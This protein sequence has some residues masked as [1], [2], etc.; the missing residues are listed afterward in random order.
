MLIAKDIF[1][2][3]RNVPRIEQHF[4]RAVDYFVV[5][6]NHLISNKTVIDEQGLTNNE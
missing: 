4:G 5:E 1:V 3:E 6:R 2:T